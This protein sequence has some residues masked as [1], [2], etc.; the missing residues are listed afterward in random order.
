MLRRTPL[1]ATLLAAVAGAHASYSYADPGSGSYSYDSG[2]GPGL[3][4][5]ECLGAL[6]GLETAC[7]IPTDEPTETAQILAACASWRG[8]ADDRENAREAC[9][10]LGDDSP[11]DEMERTFATLCSTLS[12]APPSPAKPP[13]AAA[14]RTVPL[15]LALSLAGA[16]CLLPALAVGIAA[17]RRRKA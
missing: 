8:C 12:P 1:L 9:A 2:S 14:T 16:A 4:P 7:D 5:F 17:C 15:V 11:L 6:V 13:P 10:G 3:L